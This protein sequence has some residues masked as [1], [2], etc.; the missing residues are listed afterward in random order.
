MGMRGQQGER[1]RLSVNSWPL[2]TAAHRSEKCRLLAH[3]QLRVKYGK[4]KNSLSS[5]MGV[6]PHCQWL[7][8]VR[9]TRRGVTIATEK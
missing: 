9:M 4:S 6:I 8:T 1:L 3:V 2:S 7:S 5:A